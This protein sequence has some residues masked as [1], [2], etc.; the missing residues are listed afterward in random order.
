MSVAILGGG[1]IGQL[2]VQLAWLAGAATVILATRQ[3]VRR[4]LAESLGA[5][6]TVDPRAA[7]VVAAV[8][9][10]GG[11]APGGV[12]VALECAGTVE[13]FEQAVALARRGGTVLVFRVAPQ[14]A[15]ARISPFD[16][17]ARELRIVGSYLPPT[18]TGVPWIWWPPANWPLPR[19]SRAGSR[20]RRCPQRW[21]R[22]L[23]PVK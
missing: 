17:F 15:Q 23:N 9:G 19:W 13:T 10:Q 2:M 7:E 5:T 8:A 4:T 18:R 22:H 1:V 21:H 20:W 16:I 6:A 14:G 11:L 12:D 3:A